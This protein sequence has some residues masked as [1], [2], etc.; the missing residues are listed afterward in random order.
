[1]RT[2]TF[3]FASRSF[4]EVGTC[5]LTLASVTLFLMFPSDVAR[6]AN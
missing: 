5:F 2:Y 3:V 6:V 1:M 4:E